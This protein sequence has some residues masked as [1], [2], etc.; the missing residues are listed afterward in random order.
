MLSSLQECDTIRERLAGY[1]LNSLVKE[2]AGA[3]TAHLATCSACHAEHECL[4][5]VAP[6]LIPLREALADE[7]QRRKHGRH[8]PERI[9]SLTLSQW[10][11]SKA[12]VAAR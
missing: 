8:R 12:L 1:A 5:A 4:A 7:S 2:E 11:N 3:V 9:T 10:V 6:H